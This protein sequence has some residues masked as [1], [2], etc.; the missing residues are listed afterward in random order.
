MRAM[1]MIYPDPQFKGPLTTEMFEAMGKYNE[2]LVNAGVLLA[3]EGLA[4]ASKGVRVRFGKDNKPEV[5]DGPF[6]E[7]KEVIGGFWILQVKSMDE[8]V[9][10][11]RRCPLSEGDML[12]I[13]KVAEAEDFGEAFTPEQ[14]E[15]EE[16]L[17]GRMT[18]SS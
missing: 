16:R 5:S 13:R 14:R 17:R 3:G 7:A 6:A 11:A 8:A 9:E 15:K 1:M 2:Q 12:E 4:P 18:P 10:W